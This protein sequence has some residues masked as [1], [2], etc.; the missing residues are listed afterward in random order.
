MAR[1]RTESRLVRRFAIAGAEGGVASP[2]DQGRAHQRL[3]V[4]EPLE[5]R[6][7]GTTVATTMRTPGHDFELAVG[8]CHAEGLLDGVELRG[9]RYCATGSAVDAGFNVV[10]VETS[11]R[12]RP[13]EPRLNPMTSSCGICGTDTVDRLLERLD[14]LPVGAPLS[15]EVLSSVTEWV[16]ADQEL[17]RSTGGSHAAALLSPDGRACVVREDIGRHNAVDKAVGRMVLDGDLPATG[18]ILW[19]SGRA[20]LEMVQKAWAAGVAALVS[21][22]APS[23]LAVRTAER[24][25]MVLIGFARDGRFTVYAGAD[26][27]LADSEVGIA[28]RCV[29][30]DPYI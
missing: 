11:G 21:V 2:A 28:T 23:S 24:A 4:E 10:T 8:W 16:A 13:V 25:G 9:I 22:S 6:V 27:V 12:G 26:R 14:R 1:S 19:I 20:S 29:S 18:S 17:F 15:A 3:L 5:I 7:D 30:E